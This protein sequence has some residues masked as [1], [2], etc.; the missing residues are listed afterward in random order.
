[1]RTVF[2]A[3]R[4]ENRSM[5]RALAW[6]FAPRTPDRRAVTR[7]LGGGSVRLGRASTRRLQMLLDPHL[8]RLTNHAGGAG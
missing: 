7:D 2:L 1:M 8:H 3:P 6:C 5:P 4:L